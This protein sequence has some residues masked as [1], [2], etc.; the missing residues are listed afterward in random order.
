MQLPELRLSLARPD[1]SSA[2]TLL[3]L[4]FEYS[5]HSNIHE[6]KKQSKKCDDDDDANANAG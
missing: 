3:L 4:A 6:K 5:N 1:R 2:Y